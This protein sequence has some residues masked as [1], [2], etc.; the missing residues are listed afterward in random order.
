MRHPK[1]E[2]GTV[3]EAEKDFVVR[4]GRQTVFG[5]TQER[6]EE[7]L[8]THGGLALLVEFNHGLGVCGLRIGI[9]PNRASF[10]DM[11]CRS[12]LMRVLA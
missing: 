1:T 11:R 6:T 8:T 3:W 2:K 5:F 7:T 9:C 4:I 10:A 12:A